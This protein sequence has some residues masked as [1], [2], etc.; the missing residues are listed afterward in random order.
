MERGVPGPR[1]GTRYGRPLRRP[2]KPACR[3]VEAED[4]YA[5]EP[6]V[7]DQDEAAARVR[8]LLVLDPVHEVADEGWPKPVNG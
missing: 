4:E 2:S 1:A 8:E 5:I 7:G 6:L 3:C